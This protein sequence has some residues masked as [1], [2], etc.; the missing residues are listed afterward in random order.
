MAREEEGDMQGVSEWD[1]CV[2]E[3]AHKVS[4][5]TSGPY[6]VS[7]AEPCK[8][9]RITGAGLLRPPMPT[10]DITRQGSTCGWR[11]WRGRATTRTTGPGP[12]DSSYR[13]PVSRSLTSPA[14]PA[15]R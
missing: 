10:D 14:G 15:A 8:K 5:K 13:F 11:N 9:F 4:V 3:R 6:V 7:R 2:I 12:C 1:F